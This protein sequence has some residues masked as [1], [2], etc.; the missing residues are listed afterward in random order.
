[1][2]GLPGHGAWM[3]GGDMDQK[4]VDIGLETAR[5]QQHGPTGAV[6]APRYTGPV[7]VQPHAG[8]PPT[9]LVCVLLCEDREVFRIG[10]RVVLE[11]EPDMAVVAETS[12][13]PEALEA[14][15]GEGTVVVVVR[16][17]LV[18]GDALPLLRTLCQRNT[19]VLVLAEPETDSEPELVEILRAGV[20]GFLPRR[21][22]AQ[23]LVDGVRALARHEAALDPAATSHLVRHLTASPQ[24]RSAPV[25]GTLD[26]LT[27]RQREVAE[28]VAQGMSNEEIAGRL[29]LSLATVKSHLTASM[30][31][32]GVRSR[33]E[34]A[35]L[36]TRESSP[37]A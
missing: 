30:R 21:S 37:A 13:L 36:V 7:P 32:I 3:Q 17:G 12:H 16:Q 29:F 34:L 25:L 11:A 15:E 31:R 8:R 33:T 35:I 14:A 28:L 22:G 10:L 9:T 23:R 6:P 5:R 27:D 20:R 1:M 19:A 26:R 18:A 4:V 2:S 24:A